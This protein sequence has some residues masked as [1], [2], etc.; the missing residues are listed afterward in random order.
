MVFKSPGLDGPCAQRFLLQRLAQRG[1]HTDRIT[2]CAHTAYGDHL[3]LL[4]QVDLLLDTY[5]FNGFRTTLEGLWMGVPT[6][7]LS[8][9]T[10]VSRM[11][12]AIMKQLGWEAALAAQSPQSFVDRVC[13]YAEQW[14]ALAALRACLRQTLLSSSIC[15][16]QRL[17]QSLQTAFRTIW[18]QW[19]E[20]QNP[21]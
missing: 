9:P 16:P 7:T 8:G 15:D 10:F 5:P 1:I 20:R 14:D 13:A 11:G 3:N 21:G 19:C 12:L 17:A 4:G 2:L 18:Q 6:V